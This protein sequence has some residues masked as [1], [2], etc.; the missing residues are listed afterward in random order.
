MKHLSNIVLIVLALSFF[1]CD[2]DTLSGLQADSFIK[3]YGAEMNDEGRTVITLDDGYLIMG[4]VETS[5]DRKDICVIR[6][7][8]FGNTVQP[9]VIIGGDFDDMG[10]SMKRN[11]GGFVISGS[12]RRTEFGYT[13]AY[14]VQLNEQATE[15]VW[16]V[17]TGYYMDDELRDVLILDN[18]NIICCGYTETD[19]N[20]KDLLFIE[21]ESSGNVV[22]MNHVGGTKDQVANAIVETSDAYLLAGWEGLPLTSTSGQTQRLFMYEWDGGLAPGNSDYLRIYEELNIEIVDM[23]AVNENEFYLACNVSQ[24]ESNASKV[25]IIKIDI[26]DHPT[27]HNYNDYLKYGEHDINH[28]SE[29]RISGNHLYISGT[30]YNT[31]SKGDMFVLETQLD[32]SNP[33]YFY[34]GDGSSFVANGFDLTDDGGFIITGAA[35]INDQSAITLSKLSR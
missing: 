27:I 29:M 3:Y 4:N 17:D 20:G 32:G 14:V 5:D 13:E 18:G 7:D 15:I 21:I 26:S 12:R 22:T 6:T 28:A 25:Q 34:E 30:A 8:K 9:P 31:G 23:V 33:L 16:E 19:N 24:I 1:A 35:Y 10:Y 11:D 2:D